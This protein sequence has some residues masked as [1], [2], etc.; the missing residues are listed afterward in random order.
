LK[1]LQEKNNKV[2]V[3]AYLL[4]NE[5]GS[6]KTKEFTYGEKGLG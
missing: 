2:K 5:S 6:K 4:D 3:V 1:K